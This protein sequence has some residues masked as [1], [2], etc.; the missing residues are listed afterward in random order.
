M[1]CSAEVDFVVM[2]MTEVPQ[3]EASLAVC[4]PGDETVWRTAAW[5]AR[6]QPDVALPMAD[7]VLVQRDLVQGDTSASVVQRLA[8]WIANR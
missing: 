4:V 7:P 6:E 3:H 5:W 2:G 8:Q 1:Y